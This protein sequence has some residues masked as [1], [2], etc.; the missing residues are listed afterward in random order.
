MQDPK[1]D[2]VANGSKDYSLSVSIDLLQFNKDTAL[3]VNI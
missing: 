1:G 3:I 2:T